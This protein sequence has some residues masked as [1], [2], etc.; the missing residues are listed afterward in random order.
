MTFKTLATL[1]IIVTLTAAAA[2]SADDQNKA[3]SMI[4]EDLA[5]VSPALTAYSERFLEKDL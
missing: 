1:S 3:A 5:V 4:P 2:A